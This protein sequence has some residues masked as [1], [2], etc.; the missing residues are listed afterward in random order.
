MSDSPTCLPISH[1][2]AASGASPGQVTAGQRMMWLL[3]HYQGRHGA[4]NCPVVLAF[5]GPLDVPR[6]Q[7][8]WDTVVQRHE[9]LRTGFI[10]RGSLLQR[11]IVPHR[12]SHWTI[13]PLSVGGD[14]SDVSDLRMQAA[15]REEL[16][17][18]VSMAGPC[19]RVRLWR[20]HAALHVL[21]INQH[22]LVTDAVSCALVSKE[23]GFAYDGLPLEPVTWQFDDH[24]R[25][26]QSWLTGADAQRSRGFWETAL[27][28]SRPLDLPRRA[29]VAPATAGDA[30]DT[31][32]FH[33]AALSKSVIGA[34]EQQARACHTSLFVWLLALFKLHLHRLTGG[35]D[36]S[37]GTL[38]SNRAHPLS[39]TT[40]GFLANMVVLRSL[41]ESGTSLPVLARQMRDTTA[42]AVAHQR[43]PYQLLPA[44]LVSAE[45][46]REV[47]FQLFSRPTHAMQTADLDVRMVDPPDGVARR[48]DLDLVVMPGDVAHQ[49]VLAAS[50][51][52]FSRRWSHA[53]LE[54]YL[55]LLHHA[56]SDSAQPIQEVDNA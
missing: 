11:V 9:A 10:G 6:L 23:L 7:R 4:L 46:A 50:D 47:V 28:G 48:F 35:H 15:L 45:T 13:E 33:R 17:R 31:I 3:D 40:V 56:A 51:R 43:W 5:H 27:R 14:V 16:R 20:L 32:S 52:R 54:G 19:H 25:N 53:F 21:C 22:H 8:A 26:E 1:C 2:Q 36:L 49:V 38:L 37:V 24:V 42:A 34:L 30:G 41:V 12:P 29:G 18:P 44:G 39:G 55:A